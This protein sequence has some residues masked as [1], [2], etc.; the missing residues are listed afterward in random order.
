MSLEAPLISSEA[1][2]MITVAKLGT[3]G[4]PL[5][6]FNYKPRLPLLKIK[7]RLPDSGR[8]E[9]RIYTFPDLLMRFV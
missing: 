6:V 4:R 9:G 2:T 8:L 1:L 7:Y 5:L 3:Y